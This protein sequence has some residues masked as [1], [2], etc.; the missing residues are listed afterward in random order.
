MYNIG[1]SKPEDLLGF[2][3]I[4]QDELIRAGVL[5]SDYDFE[6]HKKLVPMHPGDISMAYANT[7]TLKIL[8]LSRIPHYCEMGCGKL[9]SGIESFIFHAQQEAGSYYDKHGKCQ[10]CIYEI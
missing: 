6:A 9:H 7:C 8:D 10:L 4:L 3:A 2:V 5:L 1:N